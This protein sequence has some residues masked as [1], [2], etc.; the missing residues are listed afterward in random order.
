MDGVDTNPYVKARYVKRGF[1]DMYN[2]YPAE[3]WVGNFCCFCGMRI[4]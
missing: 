4:D 1:W 2:L 3:V